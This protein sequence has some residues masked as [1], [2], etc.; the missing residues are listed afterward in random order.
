M[1][2]NAIVYSYDMTLYELQDYVKEQFHKNKDDPT[3]FSYLHELVI[4]VMVMKHKSRGADEIDE[5]SHDFST[6]LW[7][8]LYKDPDSIEYIIQYISKYIKYYI[9]NH[10]AQQHEVIDTT[11][12][13]ELEEGL[14][15]MNM[16]SSIS[17]KDDIIK[18]ED[19]LLIEQ[20][21][22]A[23]DIIMDNVRYYSLTAEW[24]NLYVSVLISL[25]RDYT[26]DYGPTESNGRYTNIVVQ[27]A[28]QYMYKQLVR[29]H[30]E[31]TL[32]YSLIHDH[33]GGE[34]YD[35]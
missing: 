18:V 29:Y 27:I 33:E 26:V 32:S 3:L 15:Y 6:Y 21:S 12:N 16:G 17:R 13:F 30:Q 8:R 9:M 19:R 23:M 14:Q 20:L 35:D 22:N 28:K 5:I 31:D 1:L 2:K 7:H 34:I 4:R 11:D 24:Y 25:I 10:R